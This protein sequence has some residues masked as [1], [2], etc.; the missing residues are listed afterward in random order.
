MTTYK[1]GNPIGSTNPKDL[2]DNSQNMDE[3]T[4]SLNKDYWDDRLGRKR[5]TWE[6][7]T[8]L[9][10]LGAAVEAAER[11]EAAADA[12]EQVSSMSTY[13]TKADAD[14]ALPQSEG[15]Y[16]RV[17]NDPDPANNGYWVSDGSQWIWSGVQPVGRR[18]VDRI[19]SQID[20]KLD[21]YQFLNEELFWSLVDDEW[22]ATDL[23]VRKSDGQLAGF[24]VDRLALR[25][26]RRLNP[27]DLGNVITYPQVAGSNHPVLGSDFYMRD[28]EL[29]PVLTDMTQIAGWG[30]SSMFRSNAAF[31]A[32]AQSM[33]ASYYNG[34]VSGHQTEQIAARLGSIPALCSFPA[35]TI[36]A[37]TEEISIDVPDIS[38]H[39]GQDY[40]GII[41]G[42][43]GRLRYS[44]GPKFS[45]TIA[46]EP[47]HVEPRTP[48][49]PDDG[50][51]N[52]AAITF[53]WMG[54]NDLTGAQDKTESCIKNTDRSFDWLAP[55][56]KRV[57]VLGH[58]QGDLT[59]DSPVWDRIER[60]NAAHRA[61]YGRLFV[62]VNA[63]LI[64]PQ[65]WIDM[66]VTPT[67]QDL[68][69]QAVGTTPASLRA[70][71]LHLTNAAYQAVVTYCVRARMLELGWI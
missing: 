9:S 29:L 57:L 35:N 30:S 20:Q 63:Y 8:R 27:Q 56:V 7:M 5:L 26:A 60:V 17:T 68:D 40:T 49:L 42:V 31:S 41:N 44:G 71:G 50:A 16:I 59:P 1:T 38:W 53:L 23:T 22:Y 2:Y 54:R 48:F 18:D 6:G 43:H 32:L 55:L 34:G 45:R 58:F 69:Q 19:N 70:D 3:A 46:G 15:T 47:A 37:G 25:V 12:A 11:A 24:V 14:A 51:R 65:I 66:G 10:N 36:P 64:S 4:N 61:R 39:A 33:G 28:G 21:R 52:R 67:Q 13:L 62:D